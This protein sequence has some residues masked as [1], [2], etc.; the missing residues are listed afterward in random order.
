MS[1]QPQP[2]E[3]IVRVKPYYQNQ[4]PA[5]LVKN[6]GEGNFK[7][8]MKGGMQLA[9]CHIF[10]NDPELALQFRLTFSDIATVPEVKEFK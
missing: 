7:T 4:V 8:R 3:F 9:W 6:C 2:H 5:W 10:I 1:T